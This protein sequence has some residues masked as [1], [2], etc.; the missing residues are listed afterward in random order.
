LTS[1]RVRQTKHVY[2]AL[3]VLHFF[4]IV[5]VSTRET[6]SLVARGLTILP[7]AC[8]DY[9]HTLEKIPGALVGLR[10]SAK[11]SLRQTLATYLIMAGIDAGYGYF[12]PNVPVG[13]RLSFKLHYS[14]GHTET[15]IPSVNSSAGGLRF[16]SLLDQI[17]RTDSDAFREYLIRKIAAAIWREH[18]DVTKMHASLCQV[19]Q[20]SPDD[21]ELG[22]RQTC[23]L[24]YAYDFSLA[25]DVSPESKQ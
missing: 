14:D 3:F 8:S 1:S 4:V 9:A 7:S 6:L 15:Q 11:S 22:K 23:D 21:Y 16:A 20:P 17:G 2:L 24:L 12:A 10:S 13:Y 25:S 18:P 5:A 19:V